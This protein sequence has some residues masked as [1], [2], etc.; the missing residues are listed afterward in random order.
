[1]IT[2][3][4]YALYDKGQYI[5]DYTAKEISQICGVSGSRVSTFAEIGKIV[6]GR[7]C[8][9]AVDIV[10]KWDQ[11]LKKEWNQRRREILKFAKQIN[12]GCKPRK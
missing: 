1:M 9:E 5:G 6:N 7:Y 12:P 3:V 11:S 4:I 10:V 2:R 8:F